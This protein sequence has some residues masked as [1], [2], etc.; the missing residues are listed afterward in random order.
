MSWTVDDVMTR[1]PVAVAP[2]TPFKEIATLLAD[3]HIGSVPVVDAARRPVGLVTEE[4]LTLKAEPKPAGP[5]PLEGRS[6]RLAREKA[7]AEV[8]EELMR[9]PLRLLTPEASISEA[10][11]LLHREQAHALLVVDAAGALVGIVTRADI[12]KVFLRSDRELET[13]VRH[14]AEHLRK[15]FPQDSVAVAV[16][17]GVVRLTGKTWMRS[18]CER[19]AAYAAGVPGVVA[20]ENHLE[21]TVDD[22][23]LDLA[24]IYR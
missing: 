20:V 24:G 4:D 13:D 9:P 12:L 14:E 6:H 5:Y 8:A 3:R 22:Y 17:D 16:E 21:Y 1:D 18:A 7:A 23:L 15:I 11:R 10:A 19:L 2:D